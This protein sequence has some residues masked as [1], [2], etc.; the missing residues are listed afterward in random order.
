MYGVVYEKEWMRSVKEGGTCSGRNGVALVGRGLEDGK[1]CVV[2]NRVLKR[3]HEQLQKSVCVRE[4]ERAGGA[5]RQTFI[6][7]GSRRRSDEK[8]VLLRG[9]ASLAS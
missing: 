9:L 1:E 8:K 3:F 5:T 6:A 2:L 7:N 4:R